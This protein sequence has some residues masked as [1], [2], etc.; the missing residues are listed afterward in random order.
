MTSRSDALAAAAEVILAVESLATDV[1][2][3][4]V[5]TTVGYLVVEPNSMTTI[6]GVVTLT[7]D[8]RDI[9]SDRQR[10]TTAEGVAQA[11]AICDRRGVTI[12][13]EVIGDTSPTVLPTWLR[14]LAARGAQDLGV[15]YSVLTSGASHD[16]QIINRLVPTA[17]VFV[18]S[19]DGLSHV[20]EEWTSSSDIARGA[21]VL[22]ASLL[23]LDAS[24]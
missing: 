10:S 24:V 11:R 8:V 3:R 7:L 23:R 20:P 15:P 17:L 4:G 21:D 14:D 13:V 12:E 2:H 1:R 18:P 6:P 9:D 22:L 16:A 19:R 5:R